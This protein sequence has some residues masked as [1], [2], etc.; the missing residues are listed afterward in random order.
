M[1]RRSAAHDAPTAR[2]AVT[3]A[4][5]RYQHHRA[6]GRCWSLYSSALTMNWPSQ[7]AAGRST[8]RRARA[9]TAKIFHPSSDN[10]LK[11]SGC[12]RLRWMYARA[13]ALWHA[14]SGFACHQ[15]AAILRRRRPFV[16][17]NS[18]LNWYNV[19]QHNKGPNND[20]SL[21]CTA[22]EQ[23]MLRIAA[24]RQLARSW[25]AIAASKTAAPMLRLVRADFQACALIHTQFPFP[26]RT[27][28]FPYIKMN[29]DVQP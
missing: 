26:S 9:R 19:T 23:N 12:L 14:G 11:A 22:D 25:R 29:Q 1:Y 20:R 15:P 13:T 10:D 24:A 6:F 7:R 27:R 17:P 3:H 18:P 2:R 4:S 21:Y 28:R 8:C 5:T 16:Q